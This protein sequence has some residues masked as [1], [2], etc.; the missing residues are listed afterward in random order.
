LLREGVG[1]GAIL[2]RRTEVHPF[3]DKQI[4]LLETFASQAV[5]AIENVRLFQE[6]Q[7]RNLDLSEALEQQ[8]ATSEILR[9]I[10]SSPTDLQPVFETILANATRLCGTRNAGLY[11]FDGELLHFAAGHNLSPEMI[12]QQSNPVRLGGKR[13]PTA[14]RNVNYSCRTFC[15]RYFNA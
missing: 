1:I 15:R 14:A 3:T 11:R 6:L 13:Q 9:V 7:V 4:K 2:I 12:A 10:S 8:T 5:I